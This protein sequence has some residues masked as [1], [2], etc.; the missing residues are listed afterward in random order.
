MT[1]PSLKVTHRRSM[2]YPRHRHML[3]WISEGR[4]G[5]ACGCSA[6]RKISFSCI[7]YHSFHELRPCSLQLTFGFLFPVY[8]AIVLYSPFEEVKNVYLF[9]LWYQQQ[10][11]EMV[12][13]NSSLMTQ[14]ISFVGTAYRSIDE[15]I[16]RREAT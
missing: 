6:L 2:S 1:R 3:C 10:I 16:D 9:E 7:S 4:S 12:L 5:W 14:G 11:S 13:L 15:V 8:V